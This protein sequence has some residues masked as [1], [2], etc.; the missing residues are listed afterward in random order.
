MQTRHE[1][2]IQTELAIDRAVN[3]ADRVLPEWSDRAFEMVV[4]Y[5]AQ[6]GTAFCTD[7]VR[8]WATANGLDEPPNRYSWGGVMLRAK[9]AGLIHKVGMAT[10]HYPERPGTHGK[11]TNFWI[12]NVM[13]GEKNET[14]E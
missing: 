2:W 7:Q 10:H 5:T 4:V 6:N 1:D 8:Q 11:P 12:R 14:D 9:R 13:T 3:H